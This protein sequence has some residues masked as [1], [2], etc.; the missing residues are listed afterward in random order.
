VNGTGFQSGATLT[1]GGTPATSVVVVSATK[2]TAVTPA[3]IAGTVNVTVTNPDTSTGTLTNGYTYLELFDANG[4]HTIDP[5]DIFYLINYLFVGGPP[6]A[7]AAGMVSGDANGD[8]VVDPSDIF[9]LVNYLFLNGPQP[10]SEPVAHIASASAPMKGSISLGRPV[11]RGD[12]YVIPVTVE[13]SPSAMS[14]RL[15]L[16]AAGEGIAIHRSSGLQP[17]FEIV[18]HGK[19]ELTYLVDYDGTMNGVVASIEVPAGA[20]LSSIEIDGDGTLICDR[21]GIRKATVA[22]GTL[23]VNG[24]SIDGDRSPIKTPRSER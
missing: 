24:T 18:R 22:A 6:P 3:H 23:T 7:G 14:L 13:G 4:D 2:I 15:R 8:G 1:F 9:Y 5:A 11:L 20:R 10:Y 16:D 21:G 19:R 12:R 17:A